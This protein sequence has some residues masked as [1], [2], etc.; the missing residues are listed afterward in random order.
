DGPTDLIMLAEYHVYFL[1][2]KKDH[3]LDEPQKI[4]FSGTVKSV[5]VTDIDGDGRS[6][7]L[8]VNW[9]DRNP[10]RFRLQK[11]A[12]QMG[13]E[14]YFSFSPIRSYWADNLE[15][16][17]KTQI[18]TIALNSGRAQVSEFTR[19]PAEALSGRF[20]HGQF[21]VLPLNR[22]EKARSGQMWADVN[23]DCMHDL[24]VA[25]L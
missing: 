19:K 2:Q 14:N 5:Q 1:A 20:R 7:L 8:L 11:E 17:E 23:C 3:S 22:T 13:P 4:P 12:G 21:Q 25:G 24:L 18:M 10:F 6:D 9:E 15:E 16:N